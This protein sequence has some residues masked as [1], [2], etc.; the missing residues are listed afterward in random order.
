MAVNQEK[1]LFAQASISPWIF[2]W[3]GILSGKNLSL[4]STL[5]LEPGYTECCRYKYGDDHKKVKECEVFEY[6]PKNS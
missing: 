2:Q 5:D 6:E 3:K 4:G 1:L